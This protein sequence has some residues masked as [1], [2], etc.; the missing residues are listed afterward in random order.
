MSRRLAGMGAIALAA[1]VL[2]VWGASGAVRIRALE[3]EITATERDI[4]ALR[5]QARR[6][7]EA[8]DQL[9][10]DPSYIEKLGREEHGLVRQGET[11]LKFP[12]KPK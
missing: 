3:A 2:G 1:I 8:I 7:T 6:L 11:I 4:A 5:T 10:N 12:A 9:R